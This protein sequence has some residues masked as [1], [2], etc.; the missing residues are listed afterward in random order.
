MLNSPKTVISSPA[1]VFFPLALY[2]EALVRARTC[3]E[4][5][6]CAVRPRLNRGRPIRAHSEYLPPQT[7]THV[8]DNV[9]ARHYV[10][11]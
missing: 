1:R 5:M 8:H 4:P 3:G 9:R 7:H 2:S 6:G 10:R 11:A